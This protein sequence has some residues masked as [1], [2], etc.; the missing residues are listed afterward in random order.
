MLYTE[1]CPKCNKNISVDLIYKTNC[2][3][4]Y[5]YCNVP[6]EGNSS[7][8]IVETNDGSLFCPHCKKELDFDVDITLNLY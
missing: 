1:R 3:D 6:T 8:W 4:S 5:F 2:G 7:D